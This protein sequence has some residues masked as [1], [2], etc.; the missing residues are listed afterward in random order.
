MGNIIFNT[1]IV[2]KSSYLPLVNGLKKVIPDI[3][4][5]INSNDIDDKNKI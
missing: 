1:Y 5:N 3:H 4:C 2:E